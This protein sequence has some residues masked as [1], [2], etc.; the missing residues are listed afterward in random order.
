MFLWG[1]T[2]SAQ[3]INQYLNG[4]WKM[5][6]CSKYYNLWYKNRIYTIN[7]T[8]SKD[9]NMSDFINYC[10]PKTATFTED[11]EFNRIYKKTIPI[12]SVDFDRPFKLNDIGME[13]LYLLEYTNDDVING[14]EIKINDIGSSLN[15]YYIDPKE[16]NRYYV[17]DDTAPSKIVYYYRILSPPK[18]VLDFYKKI[19]FESF[20]KIRF[21]KRFILDDSFTLTKMYL[22]EGDEV[23]VLEQ[24][25]VKGINWLKIRYYGSGATPRKTI[26]GWI[27][28]ND[29]E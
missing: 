29:V 15:Y 22:I 28:K 9:D 2:T 26:E 20:K 5:E 19:A 27:K 11:S 14:R 10:V 7:E 1:L 18:Y 6:C 13:L 16:S 23:E 12:D 21:Q 24:K 8:Y 17:W 25:L 3:T 4:I